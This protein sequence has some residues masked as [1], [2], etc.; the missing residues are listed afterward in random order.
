MYKMTIRNRR[1]LKRLAVESN[2][3]MEYYDDRCWMLLFYL[4]WEGIDYFE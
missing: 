4:V 3:L 2:R 1:N